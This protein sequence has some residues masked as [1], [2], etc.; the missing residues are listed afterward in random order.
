M[1][2]LTDLS[3]LEG[4]L[5]PLVTV[6]GVAGACWLLFGRRSWWRRRAVPIATTAAV[7]VTILLFF[8]VEKWWRPFPDPI[9]TEVYV[10]IGIGICGLA[11]VI[12]RALSAGG[13]AGR[14]ASVLAMAA[15]VT[16]AAV[17]VNIVYAEF[18]TLRDALGLPEENRI[19]FAEVPKP[20]ST[21]VQGTPL[22]SVW[23]KPEGLPADG[24]VTEVPIPG[25][26][27]GFDAR[28]AQIYL[29]PAYFANPRP[30]LPVLVMMAGQPGEPADWL[31]GGKLGATMDGFAADHAG[32]APVV[33]IADAT[34]SELG[35]PMCMDSRLGNVATYLATD[36]PDWVKANLQVNMDPKAWAIGGLSYGGTCALQMA[37]NFPDRYPTFLD[38]S[39]QVEP[40]LGDRTRSVEAA[41]GGD[42]AAYTKINPADLMSSRKYPE[43]AGVFAIGSDDADFKPGQQKMFHAAQDA[44]MNV[45]YAEYPGGHSWTV[46][47]A[48]LSA[49]I[50]WL[51]QRLG[52]I[53]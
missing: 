20:T 48:A 28:D 1:G 30:L 34:G 45:H 49:Q 15:V 13:W 7:A 18:P 17:Q 2:W 44:G 40:T 29:P 33:V 47:S 26:K 19:T 3:L 50:D 36:V 24:K 46:W 10:W 51:A 43:S 9:A 39:G 8:V 38:F 12:P 4:W 42:E 37:T 5:P 41:F 31:K 53:A 27:S 14:I 16:M 32:L 25:A 21:T 22:V 52:L 11:A 6:A 23:R 35:N